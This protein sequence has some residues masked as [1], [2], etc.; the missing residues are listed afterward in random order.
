M[1][2]AD[3]GDDGIT[4]YAEDDNLALCISDAL[5]HY[6]NSYWYKAHQEFL[7]PLIFDADMKQITEEDIEMILKNMAQEAQVETG[8]VQLKL[9]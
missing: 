2:S 4:Y 3:S 5:G 7:S 9:F 8:S 1:Q 6:M